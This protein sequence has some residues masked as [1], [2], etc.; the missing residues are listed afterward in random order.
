MPVRE[1]PAQPPPPPKEPYPAEE[2]RGAE[3][4]RSPARRIIFVGGL[5]GFI[6]LVFIL[7][8]AS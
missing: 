7:K 1:G 2:A 4:L 5:I 3:I 6:A 8:A